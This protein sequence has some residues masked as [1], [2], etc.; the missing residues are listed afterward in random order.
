M[1]HM[2]L[3]ATNI[4]ILNNKMKTAQQ[5]IGNGRGS[6]G[7]IGIIA[8]GYC[9]PAAKLLPGNCAHMSVENNSSH[10]V[11]VP[12]ISLWSHIGLLQVGPLL[13]LLSQ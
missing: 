12:V 3:R 4:A 9:P 6:I 10:H 1:E 7:L 8:V 5:L 13:L 11:A 2:L